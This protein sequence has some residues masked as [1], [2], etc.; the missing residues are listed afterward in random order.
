MTNRWIGGRKTWCL[1]LQSAS[2]GW[3]F[4]ALQG[5]QYDWQYHF[6]HSAHLFAVHSDKREFCT[7]QA[8]AVYRTLP[9]RK[10]LCEQQYGAH[11]TLSCTAVHCRA[12][13]PAGV[14]TVRPSSCSPGIGHFCSSFY[15][16]V[17]SSSSSFSLSLSLSSS[18]VV[19]SFENDWHW[20]LFLSLWPTQNVYYKEIKRLAGVRVP[21]ERMQ[22]VSKPHEVQKVV[23]CDPPCGRGIKA[24]LLLFV[25]YPPFTPTPRKMQARK[26]AFLWWMCGAGCDRKP[27]FLFGQCWRT[28]DKKLWSNANLERRPWEGG[29]IVQT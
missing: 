17:L 7:V 1:N 25:Q 9:C 6:T 28:G 22:L 14:E 3:V 2:D 15:P 4:A 26:G 13:Y 18:W 5:R 27:S 12:L 10:A 19:H 24:S 8:A 29:Q 20:R 16:S 11:C 23:Y 21:V